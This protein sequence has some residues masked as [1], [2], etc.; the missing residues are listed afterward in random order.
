M[1][2]LFFL[3]SILGVV[4]VIWW[5]LSNDQV[6]PAEPT[7]GLFAMVHSVRKQRRQ[8]QGIGPIHKPEQP[9]RSRRS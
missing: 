6:G 8:A 7:R 2:A 1:D 3:S 9:P 4:L 5:M